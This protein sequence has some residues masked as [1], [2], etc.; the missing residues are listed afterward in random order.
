MHVDLQR[1]DAERVRDLLRERIVELDK[2]INRTDSSA[3][4]HRLQELDRAVQRVVDE[5]SIALEREVEPQI[6]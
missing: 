5:L 6:R 4:K 1:S 2:E 3:F